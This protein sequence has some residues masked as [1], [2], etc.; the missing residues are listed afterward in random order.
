MEAITLTKS[1]ARKIILEATGLAR[2]NQFGKGIEAVYNFINQQGFVQLDTNYVVERAHHHAM[3]ARIPDYQNEWAGTTSNG[4]K[5]PDD[6]YYYIL[7]VQGK[8]IYTGFVIVQG[9]R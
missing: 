7:N 3:F 2:K 6:T 8:G 4:E 9:S 5:L 1:Q